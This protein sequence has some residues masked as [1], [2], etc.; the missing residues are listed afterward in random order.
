[1]ITAYFLLAWFGVVL[2]LSL[3]GVFDVPT[4]PPLAILFTVVTPVFLY[5]IDRRLLHGRL[6]EGICKLDNHALVVVQTDRVVGAAFLIEFAK[7]NLPS[8]FALPAGIGDVLIGVAAPWVAYTL[9]MRKPQ[10]VQIAR[11]WNYLGILDL[12]VAVT[13]GITHSG[14]SLGIFAQEISMRPIGQYPL[15]LI[16]TW[17]V[18]LAIILH[19][20][21][22][23]LLRQP[24]SQTELGEPPTQ[25]LSEQLG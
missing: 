3:I 12:V 15:C 19:L 1:M 13:M 24:Q 18:P 6:F 11:W 10:A 22:L 9:T 2:A 7:G 21:S 4:R 14:S 17:A 5:A 20:R 16:P 25:K 23:E 8:G